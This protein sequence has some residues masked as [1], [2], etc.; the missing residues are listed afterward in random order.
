M[1]TRVMGLG[2]TRHEYIDH[3]S[4]TA[5]TRRPPPQKYHAQPVVLDGIR[6]ASKAE[7]VRYGWL[8]L[9]Q[10]INE[11]SELR[12]HTPWELH[13]CNIETGEITI[14]GRYVSD[15]DY[16]E[17]GALVVEDVKGMT[18]LPLFQWKSRH[19]KAEYGVD[20]KEI[21]KPRTR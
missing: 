20:V 9:K 11:I 14:V 4:I 13:V 5:W 8:R 18:S 16:Q 21:R 6:F 10:R 19:M 7:S 1:V 15:F 2:G 3:R 17:S 12:V